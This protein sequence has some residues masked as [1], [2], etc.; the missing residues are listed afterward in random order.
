MNKETAES[1]HNMF[2]PPFSK[3]S[4]LSKHDRQALSVRS[5]IP[6]N[7]QQKQRRTCN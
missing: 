2:N 5:Q 7:F 4:H 3:N 1:K 6:Q